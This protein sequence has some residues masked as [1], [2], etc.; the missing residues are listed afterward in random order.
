MTAI[1][2]ALSEAPKADVVRF[3]LDKSAEC[4][5]LRRANIDLKR[6]M[7][8]LAIAAVIGM[9]LAFALGR[10]ARAG[11]ALVIDGDTLALDGRTVRLWGIDAPE[12]RSSANCASAASFRATA[13][14]FRNLSDLVVRL[15]IL[16]AASVRSFDHCAS[17][18]FPDWTMTNV[19]ITPATKLI[20]KTTFATSDHQ[21]AAEYPISEKGHTLLP[22]WF[23]TIGI[24]LVFLA[25]SIALFFQIRHMKRRNYDDDASC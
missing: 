2:T 4:H 18:T 1:F 5:N 14:S 17:L 3:A 22:P 9:V 15:A 16:S 6:R 8:A 13:V 20:N 10:T 11:E 23:F 12:I 25:G 19:E 21:T 24:I 7:R